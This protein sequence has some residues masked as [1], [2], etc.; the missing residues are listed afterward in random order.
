MA[1]DP[2][3]KLLIPVL[4][5]ANDRLVH[6]DGQERLEHWKAFQALWEIFPGKDVQY[7]E[8]YNRHMI[9]N[10]L[11]VVT[12][13]MERE[14]GHE[15]VPL[16]HSDISDVRLGEWTERDWDMFS[17]SLRTIADSLVRMDAT[18]KIGDPEDE[19]TDPEHVETLKTTES[20]LHKIKRYIVVYKLMAEIRPSLMAQLDDD[21]I[22]DDDYPRNIDEKALRKLWLESQQEEDKTIRSNLN[23]IF[24]V[25]DGLS[26]GEIPSLRS[27]GEL[28]RTMNSKPFTLHRFDERVDVLMVD[29][30]DN[31]FEEPRLIPHYF[32]DEE[33]SEA[34]IHP[35]SPR[36]EE[37]QQ[38]KRSLSP[39]GLRVLREARRTLR[40][41]GEDP[42]NESMRLAEEATG[43]TRNSRVSI[44]P[45]RRRRNSQDPEEGR[46]YAKKQSAT[47]LQFDEEDDE[48]ELDDEDPN[49]D[50]RAPRLGPLPRQPKRRSSTSNK[51]NTPNKRVKKSQ[52]KKYKG[53]RSWSTEEKRAI[54]EGLRTY[55][56]GKWAQIKDQYDVTFQLRTSGQIK[57]CF[58]R[59]VAK[60]EIPPDLL[61]DPEE[62]HEEEQE[63]AAEEGDNEETQ[64]AV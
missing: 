14:K 17:E 26:P 60:G 46:L 13:A 62:Q 3:T 18:A 57:D 34:S 2:L 5:V 54:I 53:K 59:M 15:T 29:W 61:E 37:T 47:S 42:L 35:P 12:R 58:R 31:F 23:N 27:I 4:E 28:R 6:T 45:R 48:E 55:G 30:I 10:I 7:G 21:S 41:T 56:K 33:V 40:Q 24:E 19:M 22:S 32:P 8:L 51:E 38:V 25:D 1:M 36:R 64:L 49:A 9:G 20:R 50:G 39:S 43:A 52:Q 44:S 16:S 11:F 63:G